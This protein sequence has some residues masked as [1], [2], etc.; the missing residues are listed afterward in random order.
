MVHLLEKH[1]KVAIILFGDQVNSLSTL[2]KKCVEKIK[3]FTPNIDV[4][5]HK[6]KT[7]YW[8]SLYFGSLLK[9]DYEIEKRFE[10][11]IVFC[12]NVSYNTIYEKLTVVEQP[13]H[14]NTIYYFSG[15]YIDKLRKT[16]IENS[17]FCANSRTADLVATFSEVVPK[18]NIIYPLLNEKEYRDYMFYYYC[19][20]INCK[21]VCAN[22]EFFNILA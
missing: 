4:F 11:D 14:D 21:T 16:F 19:K 6:Q 2:G 8:K 1:S 10:F 13:I 15:Y 12:V 17:G 22:K 5:F 7:N 18:L 9:R 3:A 20:S